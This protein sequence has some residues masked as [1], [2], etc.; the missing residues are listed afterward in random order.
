MMRAYPRTLPRPS[1]DYQAGRAATGVQSS[2]MQ[3]GFHRSRTLYEVNDDIYSMSVVMDNDDYAVFRYFVKEE[4]GG[5]TFLAEWY[6]DEVVTKG[7]G[8]IVDGNFNAVPRGA[9]KWTVSFQLYV[10]NNLE[11]LNG[12]QLFLRSLKDYDDADAE[13]ILFAIEALAYDTDI[14]NPTG[15]PAP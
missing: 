4:V 14:L 15:H 3:S 2:K 13:A 8:H 9:S 11:S 7:R 1:R 12:Y 10:E 5:N 6:D